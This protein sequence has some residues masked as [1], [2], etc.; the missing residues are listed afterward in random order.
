MGDFISNLGLQTASNIIGAGVNQLTAKQQYER[1]KKLMEI[2]NQNQQTMMDKQQVNQMA[3]NEQ[4][5]QIQLDT[6][7]KTNFPAQM[8]M[9]K[10]AGLNPAMLYSKGGIGGTTGGQGGGSASSGSAGGGQAQMAQGMQNINIMELKNQMAQNELLKSQKLNTDADTGKKAAEKKEIESRTPTSGNVADTDISKK[11][12]EIT[13]LGASTS[14]IIANTQKTN[15]ETNKLLLEGKI[16]EGEANARIAKA[17]SEALGAELNNELTKSKTNLTNAEIEAVSVKIA[18]EAERIMQ[19]GRALDQKDK[20]I[21]INT[22]KA[23]ID[24]EYPGLWDT[25]GMALNKA[26]LTMEGISTTISGKAP[27]KYNKIK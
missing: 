10:K 24:A 23:E 12:A 19:S 11:G 15:A 2:Q 7:E 26:L 4:G 1:Q 14:Q 13:N 20:E 6:W 27:D 17:N 8:E 25:L 21:L 18:Q 16:L 9:I 5:Q 3:L 22:F